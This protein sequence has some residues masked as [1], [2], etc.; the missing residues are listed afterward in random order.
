MQFNFFFKKSIY[1]E[2]GGKEEERETGRQVGTIRWF[3]SHMAAT[4]QQP[5]LD[6]AKARRQEL[7][8]GVRLSQA[9]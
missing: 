9:H 7:H 3:A 4:L 6:Q 8:P 1:L 5:G 2:E